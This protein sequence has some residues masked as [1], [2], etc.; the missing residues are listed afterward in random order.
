MMVQTPLP[1]VTAQ[2]TGTP[3]LRGRV[4][5]GVYEFP[6]VLLNCSS[7]RALVSVKSSGDVWHRRLGHPA[8]PVLRRVLLDHSLPFQ[9]S[10]L[11]TC[12]AC[13][14]SK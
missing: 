1:L 7:P 10:T 2:P 12:S 14:C 6:A 9:S 13:H 11:S 4:R 5:N 3:L 8:P